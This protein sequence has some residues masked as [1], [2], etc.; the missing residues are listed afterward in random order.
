MNPDDAVQRWISESDNA[1]NT[2]TT[3][4]EGPYESWE[5]TEA[6]PA[7]EAP[8]S[9]DEGESFDPFRGLEVGGPD[10]REGFS[11]GFTARA[12]QW[13]PEAAP[14][15]EMEGFTEVVSE[16]PHEALV[17]EM[18]DEEAVT[19]AF[20]ESASRRSARTTWRRS[21]SRASSTRPSATP[22][23]AARSQS[24]CTAPRLAS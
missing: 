20:L 6:Y 18:L 17:G 7:T 14:P 1:F 22:A 9:F 3:T 24:S 2:A 19:S 15:Y 8:L 5:T 10:Q 13:S 4:R 12:D 11:E 21:S 23:R 16:E